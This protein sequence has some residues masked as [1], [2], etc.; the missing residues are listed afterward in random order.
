MN[1]ELVAS[2]EYRA[3]K[4]PRI[5]FGMSGLKV[6]LPRNFN[7]EVTDL[8]RRHKLWIEKRRAVMSSLQSGLLSLVE[9][10]ETQFLDL[11]HQHIKS[12]VEII[13][14]QPTRLRFRM[15]KSRWGS[16][17]RTGEI[18]LSKKLLQVPDELV[19]YVVHHEV[20]HLVQMNHGPKFWQLMAL[21][22]PDYKQHKKQLN[23]Y[24]L[25]LN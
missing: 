11:V 18:T 4:H 7:G 25:L 12:S 1:S 21:R 2:V 10:S 22:F 15:M 24:G 14:K 17:K 8:L 5:E 20:C 3:V 13:K 6:I 23:H 19:G 9:R 16:C